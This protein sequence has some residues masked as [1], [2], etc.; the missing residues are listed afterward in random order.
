MEKTNVITGDFRKK[1]AVDELVNKYSKLKTKE[2]KDAYLKGAVQFTDYINFEVVGE[3][4][5]NI[6]ANSCY[7]ADGNVKIDSCKKYLMYVFAIFDQYTNINVD[8]KDWLNQF[9]QLYRYGLVDAVCALIPE[10]NM[11]TLDSVLKM[12][13][14][15][16][17]TNYYEPHAFVRE[18][19]VKWV[20]MLHKFIDG[21]LGT[22]ETIT[23]EV[24][25]KELGKIVMT[26]KDK[27]VDL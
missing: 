15:D 4:C 11:A 7:D 24:D 20:P 18:Q 19:I 2:A 27:G 21:F 1:V 17:M 22:I 16:M 13:T 9:N 25:W 14:D 10:A 26:D 3:I 6:L 12:K 23:K 8:A 5:T